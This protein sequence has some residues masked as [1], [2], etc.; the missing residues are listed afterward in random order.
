M[1]TVRIFAIGFPKSGTTTLQEALEQA[2][3]RAAHWR[4]PAGLCARLVYKA[5]DRGSNPFRYFEGYEAVTQADICRPHFNLW[6]QLDHDLIAAAR[7]HNPGLKLLLNTRHIPDLISSIRRWN[8]LHELITAHD[9]PGLPAGK[10]ASDD[11]LAGW[12]AAHYQRCREL[13]GD[14]PDFFEYDIADPAAPQL[15][16]EFL[17]L[18]LPWW[19]VLRENPTRA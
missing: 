14:S 18:E 5:Y 15:L 17:G 19:G 8:N 6:P 2:G 13:Y 12:I 3:L 9:I 11:E 1:S 4:I 10:G 16:G 7:E